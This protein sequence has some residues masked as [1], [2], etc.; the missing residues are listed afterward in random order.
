MRGGRG[1]AQAPDH[2]KDQAQRYFIP[3]IAM[4]AMANGL[5][6]AIDAQRLQIVA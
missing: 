6:P 5:E 2:A 4:I 1:L 3:A